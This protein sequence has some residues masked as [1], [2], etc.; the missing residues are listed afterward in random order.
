MSDKLFEYNFLWNC[1]EFSKEVDLA[2]QIKVSNNVKHSHAIFFKFGDRLTFEDKR[3]E[4]KASLYSTLKENLI[5]YCCKFLTFVV[6][7][8]N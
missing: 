6:V 7:I 1:L 2:I 5:L 3:L 8:T 4:S